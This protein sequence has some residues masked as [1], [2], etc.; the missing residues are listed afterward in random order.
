MAA[1]T[2][3]VEFKKLNL[4]ERIYVP[5]IVRGLMVTS[6]QFFKNFPAT[7][8]R[9]KGGK[10]VITTIQYP[11]EKRT[12]PA[13]FRGQHRLML[14]DDKKT[15]RCV[16]CMCCST[17]CPSNCI[18]IVAQ[19][20]SDPAIEKAPKSFVIDELRCVFCGF[21][22]EAC[23]CDAIRL[24]SGIHVRPFY[25]RDSAYYGEKKLSSIGDKSSAVQGGKP[26]GTFPL[27][28]AKR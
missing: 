20:S 3:V 28:T 25:Q 11:D 19:E 26:P 21:C 15:L 8:S 2:K 23:P 5:E 17:V 4:L 1:T 12:Y 18:E 6:R 16:A 22:E 14:R 27:P 13:R 10:T 24:D 9:L 7:Q